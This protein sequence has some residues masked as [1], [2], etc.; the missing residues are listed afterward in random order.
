MSGTANRFVSI[1][2][3]YI[4][5]CELVLADKGDS[6]KI[7]IGPSLAIAVSKYLK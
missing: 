1:I 5:N 6:H 2:V 7:N 3:H 4:Q